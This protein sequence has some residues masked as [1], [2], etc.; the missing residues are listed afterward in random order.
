MVPAGLW[1]AW[2]AGIRGTALSGCIVLALGMAFAAGPGVTMLRSGYV[3]PRLGYARHT[4]RTDLAALGTVALV[5]T[6]LGVVALEGSGMIGWGRPA[7]AFILLAGLGYLAREGRL[8]R[9]A[10]V[11]VLVASFAVTLYVIGLPPYQFYSGL[12]LAT[13]M[14]LTIS[15]GTAL[16]SLVMNHEP[17]TAEPGSDAPG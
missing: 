4:Q 12:V 14:L 16:W 9:H 6:G 5:L 8:A 13:A 7:S 2:L 15:G 3:L 17:R 1:L 11:A 10:I